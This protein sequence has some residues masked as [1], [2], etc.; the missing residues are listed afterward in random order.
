MSSVRIRSPACCDT[1]CPRVT[2]ASNVRHRRDLRRSRPPSSTTS[3][4]RSFG[5]QVTRVDGGGRAHVQA[6]AQAQPRPRRKMCNYL[7]GLANVRA[8]VTLA[9][10]VGTY[11]DREWHGVAYGGVSPQR[12]RSLGPPPALGRRPGARLLP[13]P[14]RAV[15]DRCRC[16]R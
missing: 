13:P 4:H 1:R 9:L 15:W 11:R 5:Q 7:A 14:R 8:S 3:K 10:A 2:P 12:R 16:W 6:T